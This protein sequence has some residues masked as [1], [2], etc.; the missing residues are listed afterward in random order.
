MTRYL[1]IIFTFIFWNI[2][3]VTVQSAEEKRETSFYLSSKVY[4]ERHPIDDSFFMSQ[5]GFMLGVN[6]A[7]NYYEDS[8]YYGYK[9]SSG[10]GSV[11]YTSA[12]SGTIENIMDY[13]AEET[14]YIGKSFENHNSRTTIFSGFGG[15]YLLNAS[16]HQL[17]STGHCGYDRESRY[18][19]IPIGINFE[20]DI[21]ELRGEYQHFLY[22]QQTSKISQCGFS[23]DVTNNQ[24]KGSG[25]KLSVRYYVQDNAEV[26]FGYEFYMDYWDIADSNLDETGNFMEPRNTT[27]ESGV[28]IVWSY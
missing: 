16:G 25:L 22:G 13:Y 12:S 5:E 9:F 8:F 4:E 23:S 6:L 24:E 20:T 21:W 14:L 15:R 7:T 1:A 28:R 17:T 26:K 27:A 11:D 10:I 3:I 18:A 19:Y 2:L